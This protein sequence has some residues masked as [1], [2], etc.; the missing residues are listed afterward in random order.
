M[1][2]PQRMNPL[3]L[4]L[5]LGSKFYIFCSIE[6]L[7]QQII[8]QYVVCSVLCSLSRMLAGLLHLLLHERKDVL[9]HVVQ[10]A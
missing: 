5:N 10:Q 8:H 9:R 4:N 7:Q 3:D 1:Y 6:R 2:A